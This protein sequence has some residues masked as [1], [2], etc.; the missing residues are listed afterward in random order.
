MYRKFYGVP[1]R[2]A[3]GEERVRLVI[4]VCAPD[5]TVG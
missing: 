2:V 5:G 4:D 3:V 1:V